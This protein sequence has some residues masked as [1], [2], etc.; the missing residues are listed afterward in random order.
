[1][2]PLGPP[3]HVPHVDSWRERHG[4]AWTEDQSVSSPELHHFVPSRDLSATFNTCQHNLPYE[5]ERTTLYAKA[6]RLIYLQDNVLFSAHC[7]SFS[8]ACTKLL[9]VTTPAVAT[10]KV[11]KY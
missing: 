7:P 9:G 6:I 10:F 11:V 5:R 1:M 4:A 2:S 8:S 3:T